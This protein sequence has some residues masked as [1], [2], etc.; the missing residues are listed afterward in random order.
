MG[1]EAST[2]RIEHHL[3]TLDGVPPWELWLTLLTTLTKA[4]C[5]KKLPNFLPAN[6]VWRRTGFVRLQTFMISMHLDWRQ[7]LQ[8]LGQAGISA[9]QYLRL[10]PNAAGVGRTMSAGGSVHFIGRSGALITSCFLRHDVKYPTGVST[11]DRL[12]AAGPCTAM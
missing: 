1:A 6:T 7:V 9:V 10:E 2:R 11:P 3:G 12:V 5:R 8:G 4:F